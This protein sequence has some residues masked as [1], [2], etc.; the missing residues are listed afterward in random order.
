MNI[1][2]WILIWILSGFLAAFIIMPW[3]FKNFNEARYGKESM[4]AVFII[5]SIATGMSSLL[6]GFTLLLISFG[7]RYRLVKKI[8]TFGAKFADKINNF[9]KLP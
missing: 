8:N 2:M 6:V 9:W 7:V 3:A 1:W 4:D 5:F